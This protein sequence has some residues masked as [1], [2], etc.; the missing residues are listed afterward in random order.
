MAMTVINAVIMASDVVLTLV[1]PLW[2]VHQTDAPAA[3]V[4]AVF[5]INT[6]MSVILQVRVSRN[7]ETLHQA[8]RKQRLS[9]L[10][11]A[12]ASVIL[13]L[14]LASGGLVTIALLVTG[15]AL[16]SLGELLEAAGSWGISYDLAPDDRRGSTSPH[17]VSAPTLWRW[18]VRSPWFRWWSTTTRPGG[19]C[20]PCFSRL[21]ES[22]PFPLPPGPIG[23]GPQRRPRPGA[24]LSPRPRRR[25][26]TRPRMVID[27]RSVKGLILAAGLGS[28]MAPLTETNVLV[29]ATVIDLDEGGLGLGLTY[30]DG[31]FGCTPQLASNANQ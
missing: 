12:A 30:A 22:S 7:S 1:L 5:F 3:M 27:M 26:S 2:I 4:A 9:G 29:V 6:T 24:S 23:S 19:W 10:V 20:S 15:G 21:P 17:T 18:W 11:L 14:T 16:L 25:P 8:A 13:A 28:R 31:L